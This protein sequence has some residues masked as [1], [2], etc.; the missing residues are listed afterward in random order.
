MSEEFDP[1]TEFDL[2]GDFTD[3]LAEFEDFDTD[4]DDVLYQQAVLQKNNMVAL[5]CMKSSDRPVPPSAASIRA[6]SIRRY[7]STT[8]PRPP[9]N[10]TQRV[11]EQADATAGR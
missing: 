10:G 11:C 1:K 3:E 6:K 8:I 4:L 9:L 5:L 7:N 2:D